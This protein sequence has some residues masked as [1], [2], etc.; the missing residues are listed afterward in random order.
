[1]NNE[2]RLAEFVGIMLGDGSIGQYN[3][4][5]KDKIKIHRRV[6][7][8]LDSRNK[9]YINY[10]ATIMKEI[11]RVE[12]KV[13]FRKGENAVDISTYRKDALKF[14]INVIGLKFSPKWNNMV[15]PEQLRKGKLGLMVL[16]GLFDTDGCL[17]MF[18]NNGTIYPR[19][20]I[21]LS[22]SPAQEQINSILDE[23]DFHYKI[24]SQDKGKTRIRI[25][26]INE[27]NKWFELIGSSNPIHIKKSQLF[28]NKV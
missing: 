26:G 12:P 17:S 25:S 23:Y 5:V 16:R 22:P 21:R 24:Q 28:L 2:E 6:K 13:Y 7:V 10:V 11:L 4:K 14:V 3:T 20:E 8:T 18:N 9:E 19:I 1:M 27:L 15:V